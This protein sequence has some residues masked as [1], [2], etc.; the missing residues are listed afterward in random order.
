V[1]PYGDDNYRTNWAVGK[2]F[3]EGFVFVYQMSAAGPFR[4]PLCAC[5][6]DNPNKKSAQDID[7]SS[8]TYDTIDWLVKTSQ[9][10]RPGG[11]LR[12]LLPRLHA[13]NRRD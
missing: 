4:R 5:A 13:A 11:H 7:E 10:Q 6:P 3:R 1:A 8:D 12:N 2:F 9:Q